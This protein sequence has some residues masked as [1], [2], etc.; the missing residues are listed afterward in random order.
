MY[1][2]LFMYVLLQMYFYVCLDICIYIYIYMY[3]CV[4]TYI[5]VYIC[6]YTHIRTRA[7]WIIRSISKTSPFLASPQNGEQTADSR[8]HT[9]HNT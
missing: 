6:T 5:C 3:I 7:Y 9:N 1:I 8:A 2:Y 4:Y